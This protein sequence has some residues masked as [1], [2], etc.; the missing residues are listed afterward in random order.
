MAERTPRTG[1]HFLHAVHAEADRGGVAN[2]VRRLEWMA[3]NTALGR[4]GV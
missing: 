2:F 3:E 4:L 1:F